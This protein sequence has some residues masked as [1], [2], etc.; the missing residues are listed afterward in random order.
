MG[1]AILH[2]LCVKALPSGSG[3]SSQALW[4]SGISPKRARPAR[5]P[6]PPAWQ[7]TEGK[8]EPGLNKKELVGLPA[9]LLR[10]AAAVR[11]RMESKKGEKKDGGVVANVSGRGANNKAR[12]SH[13]QN[14]CPLCSGCPWHFPVPARMPL[15]FSTVFF[16]FCF[17]KT[18]SGQEP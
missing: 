10:E 3:V 6:H 7:V 4:S 18:K 16:L 17:A 12:T 8:K 15:A 1:P 13:Y 9:H 2:R 11:E 14:L 5:H